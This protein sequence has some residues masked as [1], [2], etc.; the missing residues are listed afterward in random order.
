MATRWYRAPELLLGS[1]TYET[2][3]DIFAMGCIM[4][5]LAD[6]QPLFPGESEIDQLYIIQRVLGSV[7][8]QQLDTFMNNPRFIGLKFPDMSKPVKSRSLPRP[9][10][11]VGRSAES[12]LPRRTN[13]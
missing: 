3:V 8:S 4:G 11:I 9:R 10:T 12:S 2:S 1:T 6:G 13:R 7:T 5:E